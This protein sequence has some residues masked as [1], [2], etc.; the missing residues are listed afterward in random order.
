MCSNI[1]DPDT[2][3]AFWYPTPTLVRRTGGRRAVQLG[4]LGYFDDSCEFHPI[5]N[6][7]QSYEQNIAEGA[8]PPSQPYQ[9]LHIDR[10]SIRQVD[11]QRQQTYTSSNI[12]KQNGGPHTQRCVGL[13]IACSL[14]D[15]LPC[16]A[17]RINSD[18]TDQRGEVGRLLFYPA[19]E[20]HLTSV[21]LI[22]DFPKSSDI[23]ASTHRL[24]ISTL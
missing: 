4:D 24:G 2:N 17:V 14:R 15:D 13:N 16:Y 6:I 19:A 18:A 5:F 12:E 23:S 20:A 21:M 8:N 10:G 3:I 9:H 1:I 7:F 11:I 22:S